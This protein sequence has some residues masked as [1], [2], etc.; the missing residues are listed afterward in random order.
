MR[1]TSVCAP[2]G[3]HDGPAGA[4]RDRRALEDHVAALGERR[5]LFE[6][7][8][9]ALRN[10]QRLARQ[11]RFVNPQ[12]DGRHESRIGGHAVSR[13]HLDDVAR[14]ERVRVDQP[15]LSLADDSRA[16]D[17]ELE[18]RLHRAAGAPLGQ[19]ADERVDDEDRGDRDGFEAIAEK[20]RQHGRSQEQEDDHAGELIAKN[21]QRR[22]GGRRRQTIR[23]VPGE[24]RLR[25]GVGQPRPIGPGGGERGVNRQ[26]MP[27]R[28]LGPAHRHAHG[29]RFGIS[30]QNHPRISPS[31]KPTARSTG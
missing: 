29:V 12:V 20:Q 15:Q 4:R 1:P 11:R 21:R 27:V 10:R 5:G 2:V 16:R 18:Q 6:L 14:H 23:P 31:L 17:V 26:R 30:T 8:V 7:H 28:S 13:G 3:D 9:R 24:S 22:S 25:F 19:E